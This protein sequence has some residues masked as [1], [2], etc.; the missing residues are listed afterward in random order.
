M[1]YCRREVNEGVAIKVDTV[2]LEGENYDVIYSLNV[3]WF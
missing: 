1:T 2:A 3:H